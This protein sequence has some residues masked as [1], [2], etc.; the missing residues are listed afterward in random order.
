MKLLGEDY[1]A[2]ENDQSI[3]KK[4]FWMYDIKQRD[5]FLQRKRNWQQIQSEAYRLVINKS[6][7][8]IPVNYYILIGS[9]YGD[10]DWIK[11][12]ELMG[13]D[14]EAFVMSNTLETG[15][16]QIESIQIASYIETMFMYPKTKNPMPVVVGNNHCILISP[17]DL[18]NK[19]S[20][21]I[22]NDIIG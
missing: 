9:V 5:F 10:L 20:N 12:D 18:Y 14:F 17:I 2:L 3:V 4:Y 6:Y 7:V 15:T 8:D 1:Q 21:F 19:T 16:W 13:R 22:F 11:V